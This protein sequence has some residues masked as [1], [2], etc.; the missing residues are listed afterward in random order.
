MS[1]AGVVMA[2]ILRRPTVSGVVNAAEGTGVVAPSTPSAG[3]VRR[4]RR[5]WLVIAATCALIR[6]SLAYVPTMTASADTVQCP[7][8]DASQT[9]D[10]R[11]NE[12]V[13]AMTL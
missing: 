10:Q 11:T 4:V 9:P 5:R 6:A 1:L 3:R 8:L 13:A 7:W 2:R 12:L